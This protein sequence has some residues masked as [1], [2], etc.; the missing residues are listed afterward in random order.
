MKKS[1]FGMLF[2]F[3]ALV[4]GGLANTAA[5]RSQDWGCSGTTKETCPDSDIGCAASG[6][7]R[8]C[9]WSAA[10]SHCNCTLILPPEAY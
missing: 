4:V 8:E 7:H 3:V 9:W 6:T 2:L 5:A 1:L 10:I